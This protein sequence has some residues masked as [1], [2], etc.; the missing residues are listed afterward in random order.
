MVCA[1][2]HQVLLF[3]YQSYPMSKSIHPGNQK[4]KNQQKKDIQQYIY[5]YI[6]DDYIQYSI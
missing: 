2:Y 6:I 5:I 3:N 4:I 1:L